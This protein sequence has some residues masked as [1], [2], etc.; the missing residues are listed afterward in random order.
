M[1]RVET[2]GSNSRCRPAL[3]EKALPADSTRAM[4]LPWGHENGP[5][6]RRPWVTLALITA[7]VVIV[8]LTEFDPAVKRFERAMEE[9]HSYWSA[10]PYLEPGDLLA[11]HYGDAGAEARRDFQASLAAGEVPIPQHAVEAEQANLD[12]LSGQAESVLER[13]VWYRFGLI[14]SAP[15]I[16]GVFGHLFL[17]GGWAHLIGNLLFLLLT[18]P[19][20]E[21]RWGR[22]SYLLFY[23][24][25]GIAAGLAYTVQHPYLTGPLIGAS[26]AIA[27]AMGAFLVV[28]ATVRIKFAYWLGLFWGTFAV[29]AWLL[30]P[31]WFGHELATARLMDVGGVSDGVAYWAHVGGFAFGVVA[32]GLLKVTGLDAILAAKNGQGKPAS[33]AKP[34]PAAGVAKAVEEGGG[35]E[36]VTASPLPG[37]LWAAVA[38]SDR[39]GAL[40][41]WR[42]L[43]QAKADFN[44]GSPEA[45]LRLAG[46]LVSRGDAASAR[47]LLG[48]LLPRA[49][50]DVAARIARVAGQIDPDLA[51]RAAEMVAGATAA[52][53]VAP[54]LQEPAAKAVPGT[55]A[56]A[57]IDLPA[58]DLSFASATE[59]A[60]GSTEPAEDS[61]FAASDDPTA[62]DLTGDS[63]PDFGEVGT[64]FSEGDP[65]AVDLGLSNSAP[66]D[67][68][69]GGPSEDLGGDETD[70]LAQNTAGSEAPS[71]TALLVEEDLDSDAEGDLADLDLDGL[72]DIFGSDPAEV[73][74]TQPILPEEP[75]PNEAT[76]F[77][78]GPF[79]SGAPA[80]GI[81]DGGTELGDLMPAGSHEA[82]PAAAPAG[83]GSDFFEADAVDLTKDDEAW[84]FDGDAIG[85]DEPG[86][87]AAE[88]GDELFESDAIDL[89]SDEIE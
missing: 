30:L 61:P 69:A 18:G 71:P 79:E 53:Q 51:R 63:L 20:L 15:R 19:F 50:D 89:G 54:E 40:D 6:D 85:L 10:H 87:H 5:L 49:T 80:A 39:P 36:P 17:H 88:A 43:R 26:G 21:N 67:L 1:V 3:Q 68:L 7:C 22:T 29:P 16:E 27:G 59:T 2:P 64:D 14:P 73:S 77:D 84:S 66:S 55:A 83:G 45:T 82:P 46:W 76:Q 70:F 13:H 44:G 81:A 31:L 4:L 56:N 23:L 11:D 72:D 37:L 65:S 86:S 32:A 25:A 57:P 9:A 74:E 78:P 8:V 47:L 12:E 24:G 75:D 60:A 58:D 62:L 33:K 35:A 42:A 28:F 52:K 41:H 48:D 34:A 38:K